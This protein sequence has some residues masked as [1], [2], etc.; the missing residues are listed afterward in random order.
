MAYAVL[1]SLKC[2]YDDQE[3]SRIY[4]SEKKKIKKAFEERDK[5]F[6][7]AKNGQVQLMRRESSRFPL[8]VNQAFMETT[9]VKVERV[10]VTMETEQVIYVVVPKLTKDKKGKVKQFK[11]SRLNIPIS[12]PNLSEKKKK[13][14]VP[15]V[16]SSNIEIVGKPSG[17]EC[18][19]W[20]TKGVCHGRRCQ[21]THTPEFRNFKNNNNY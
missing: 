18:W 3:W 21:W 16:V 12:R 14:P 11:V 2:L 15:P 8:W 6:L 13:A 19:D 17:R 9:E 10:L 4:E 1:L 5:R 20:K 7:C